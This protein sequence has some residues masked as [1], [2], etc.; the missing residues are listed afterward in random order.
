MTIL[1]KKSSGFPVRFKPLNSVILS[2]SFGRRPSR[3]VSDA[4]ASSRLLT[5]NLGPKSQDAATK[6][7]IFR[8]VLRP[9]EGLRMTVCRAGLRKTV[10]GMFHASICAGILTLL[11]GV[12]PAFSQQDKFKGIV[13]QGVERVRIAV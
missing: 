3:D 5:Q 6:S 7:D 9:K 11:F 4:L 12:I 10:L 8:E 2:P 13:D 1:M